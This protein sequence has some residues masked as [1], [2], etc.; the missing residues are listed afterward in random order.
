MQHTQERSATQTERTPKRK[1]ILVLSACTVKIMG[2]KRTKEYPDYVI[3]ALR[4]GYSVHE[5]NGSYYLYR[6]SSATGKFTYCGKIMSDSTIVHQK[7][8]ESIKKPP[9]I[10]ADTSLNSLIVKDYVTTQ[11]DDYEFGFTHFLL[12]IIDTDKTLLQVT[13]RCAIITEI[14]LSI[15]PDSY[16]SKNATEKERKH[17]FT[18]RKKELILSLGKMGVHI[19][20]AYDLL[21]SIRMY[22]TADKKVSISRV[23]EAQSCFFT[24]WNVKI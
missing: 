19:A 9:I 24:K 22:E 14:I 18:T 1:Y 20:E 10:D 17:F 6:H 15:S 11:T 5:T 21:K 23:S 12:N 13:D 3:A 4:P 7:S 16:L 8:G 2:R